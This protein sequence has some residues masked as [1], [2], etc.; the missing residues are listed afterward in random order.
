[1]VMCLPSRAKLEDLGRVGLAD[2][3]DEAAEEEHP[4][5]IGQQHR[6]MEH[7]RL[8]HGPVGLK[9]IRAAPNYSAFRTASTAQPPAVCPASAVIDPS[10]QSPPL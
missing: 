1:M 10:R 3:A 5:L 7:T 9:P 4:I 8:D 2:G 6:G